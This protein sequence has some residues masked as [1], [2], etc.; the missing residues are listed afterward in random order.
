MLQ[1]LTRKK[2]KGFTL[3][4]LIVVIAIIAILSAIVL[5]RFMNFQTSAREKSDISTAKSIATVVET[6]IAEE[7]IT[8]PDAATAY[9]SLEIASGSAVA[10]VVAINTFFKTNSYP[11]LKGFGTGNFFVRIITNGDVTV[12]S[13]AFTA[14]D[15]GGGTILYP[16]P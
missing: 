8:L 11:V 15:A 2:N 9:V 16:R 10:D 7:K 6:L 4:E 14:A 5:P 1:T 13:E 3:I 12:G